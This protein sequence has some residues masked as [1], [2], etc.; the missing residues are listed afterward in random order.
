MEIFKPFF[1]KYQ[2]L[3][4]IS[5]IVNKQEIMKKQI[6]CGK[7]CKVSAQK[8]PIKGPVSVRLINKKSMKKSNVHI[9]TNDKKSRSVFKRKCSKSQPLPTTKMAEKKPVQK[10]ITKKVKP[11]LKIRKHKPISKPVNKTG[12]T[13][14]TIMTKN[15]T[16][17]KSP[18][19]TATVMNKRNEKRETLVSVV[20][21]TKEE[22][23]AGV[24]FNPS[25]G[26]LAC[27]EGRQGEGGK[28]CWGCRLRRLQ[29]IQNIMP[30]NREERVSDVV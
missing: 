19:Q 5:V 4:V 26:C 18:K 20:E 14:S 9:D 17:S 7:A 23:Q 28:N 29:N 27:Q 22:V 3:F 1:P 15:K 10:R 21:N 12:E 25:T 13:K 2:R 30:W 6:K 16:E 24:V 8:P 11:N